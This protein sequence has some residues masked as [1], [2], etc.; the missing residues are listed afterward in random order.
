M[1]PNVPDAE[2]YPNSPAFDAGIWVLANGKTVSR[3]QGDQRENDEAEG[4]DGDTG[5]ENLLRGGCLETGK[6]EVCC[7]PA[8]QSGAGSNLHI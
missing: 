7:H 6:W 3:A 1:G 4:T 8:E 2:A 5:R